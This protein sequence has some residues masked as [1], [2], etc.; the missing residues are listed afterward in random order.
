M[1]FSLEDDGKKHFAYSA[2]FGFGSETS[3]HYMTELKTPSR[4][5]LATVIGS[6]PGLAKEVMDST[7]NDN[8]FSKD[9]LKADIAGAFTGAVTGAI[10]NGAL[11]ITFDGGDEKKVFVKFY[12]TY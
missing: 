8:F 2:I 12:H 7:E 11:Q 5:F 9:D 10:F 3:L 4:V 1:A 6:M